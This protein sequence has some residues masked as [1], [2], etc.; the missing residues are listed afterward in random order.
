MD[1]L[2]ILDLIG[3]VSFT[4]SGA[5]V[6]VRKKM[7]Y[8]GICI[9]GLITA[10]GGGAIRDITIGNTPPVMFRNP[11]YAGISFLV[12]NIVF[13][14]LYRRKVSK[15]LTSFIFEKALF[16]FD[17][18][19]LASFTVNGV[20]V[21]QSMTDGGFFLC[22]FLGVITGVGGG[23]IRDLLADTVPAIFVKHVYAMASICGALLTCLLW[24]VSVPA[25]VF[26]GLASVVVIRVL[27][28]HF[29]WNLPKIRK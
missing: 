7:D 22:S 5:L 3:V 12:S 20:I 1:M 9:L 29:R 16:W 2:D 10:F 17:T 27:A 8:L 23:V 4:I 26:S 24:N 25:A 13:I 14:V 28:M 15:P 6:A 19:G 11:V 21:G 18:V